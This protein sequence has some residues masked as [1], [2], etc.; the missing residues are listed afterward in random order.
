M[1]MKLSAAATAAA[2]IALAGVSHAT[3]L[4][5]A[6]RDLGGNELQIRAADAIYVTCV[7]LDITPAAQKSAGQ[8][9]LNARCADMTQQAFFLDPTPNPDAVPP[10][11]D[12]Y[13]LSNSGAAAA[14]QYLALL[15]QFT[16]EEASTQGRYATEGSTSQFKS[17]AGR[18]SAIRRGARVSGLSFN[19]Q[20]VD[21]I[22]VADDRDANGYSD[23]YGGAAGEGDG[24]SGWAWFANVEYG[25]GE[26][27][28]TANENGYESDSYGFVFGA[29]YAFNDALVGGASINIHRAEIDFD[30][31]SAAG[32]QSVSGGGMDV[33][34]ES[35][36]LFLNYAQ[37]NFFA[38]AIA[39][40][41]R[42]E[43]DMDRS[44]SVPLTSIRLP[45]TSGTLKS[46]TDTEQFSAQIQAGWS[47]GEGATSW[48]LY[49][50]LE[51][52][53][54]EIDRFV[55]TGSPLG[56]SFGDQDIDSQ[57]LMIGAAVRR[58]INTERGVL[59]PYA[60]VEFRHE[61]DNDSRDLNARYTLTIIGPTDTFQGSTDN[62]L[63]PTDDPDDN[64]F[65]VTVGVSA[66]FGNN[67]AAFAQF[68][69]LLGMEDV[70]AN[71]ITIGIRGSF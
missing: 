39:S 48:D 9:E 68:N 33:D 47:F 8:L 23:L 1:T 26:R 40:F 63:I 22:S 19:L 24:D 15:Q 36:S 62:F 27:D 53:N 2:A 20:G 7:S 16:G 3:D 54:L 46:S 45:G 57:E 25:W 38:S 10:A 34:S 50:G 66:Q 28:R 65:D 64:Y 29:D 43:I 42:G 52:S 60:S 41:G 14:A 11:A 30:R 12:A 4:G 37:S 67:I 55:E 58:A 69:S 31:E 21:V 44:V 59:V 49:G 35:L 51:H 70:S 61:L 5:D 18:L 71:V 17:L 32:V 56:L 6:I 13:G